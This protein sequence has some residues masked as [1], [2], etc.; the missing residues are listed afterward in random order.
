MRRYA[1]EDIPLSDGKLIPKGTSIAIAPIP[2]LDEAIYP[3]PL[4]FDGYRSLRLRQ[5]ATTTEEKGQHQ[6]TTTSAEFLIFGHGLHA[7]PG[8]AFAVNEIKLV[9]VHLLLQY[10][11]QWPK[12]GARLPEIA[13]GFQPITNPAQI[14]MY[15]KRVPELDLADYYEEVVLEK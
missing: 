11:F 13:A 1:W 10:E 9:M 6:A 15:R 5:A 14:I 12:E 8:R 3:D 4:K 7:C 2:M